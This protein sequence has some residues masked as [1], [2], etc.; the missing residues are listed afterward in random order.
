MTEEDELKIRPTVIAWV[1]EKVAV[2]LN[3][4]H[5]RLRQDNEDWIWSRSSLYRAM[6]RIGFKFSSKRCG[7]YEVKR[8]T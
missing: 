1:C 8:R 5:A 4:I 3:N 6:Y 7:H 2:N